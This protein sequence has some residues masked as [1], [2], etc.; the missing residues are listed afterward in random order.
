M[1]APMLHR[2]RHRLAL[3]FPLGIAARLA[4][5]FI[6]VA[7]LAATANFIARETVSV[8]FMPP[9]EMPAPAPVPVSP[10]RVSHESLVA[11]L[12]ALDQ[13]TD[14]N[15]EHAAAELQRSATGSARLEAGAA[16]YVMRSRQ[17][18]RLSEAR[19]EA[20]ASRAKLTATLYERLR[21]ALDGSLKIFGRVL[22]RQSL[23][24]LRN[25]FDRVRALSETSADGSVPTSS[26][27]ERLAAAENE[28]LAVF[29][30]N[31]TS[32]ERSEGAD[33]VAGMRADF[34]ALVAAQVALEHTILESAGA[35]RQLA[36]SR[37]ALSAAILSAEDAASPSSAVPTP[38]ALPP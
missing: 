7:I 35:M 22:A 34:S 20:H 29:M 15:F 38:L 23:V 12:A 3:I 8:V 28:Y 14:G 21:N 17:L 32:L 9:R 31:Q 5:S 25:D 33:W 37:A 19:R 2:I 4:L 27:R 36:Q 26:E 24:E 18:I 1:T 6:A 11:G 13:A 30:A 16:E 10:K